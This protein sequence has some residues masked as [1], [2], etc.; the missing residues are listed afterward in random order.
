[1]RKRL[2]QLLAEYGIVAVVLYF[3]IFFLVLGGVWI[4]IRAGWKPRSVSG[5]LGTFAAVYIITKLTQPLRIAATLVLTP[6]VARLYEKITG[7]SATRPPSNST[8]G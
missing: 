4:G 2:K 7:R 6:F 1:M 5:G 8:A 3:L